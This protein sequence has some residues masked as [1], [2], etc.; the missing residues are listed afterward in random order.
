MKS[1][2]DSASTNIMIADTDLKIIFV[3]ETL[4]AMLSNNEDAIK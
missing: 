1:A 3:N 2:L 4:M